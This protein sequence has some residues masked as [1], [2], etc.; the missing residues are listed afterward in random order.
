MKEKII[1]IKTDDPFCSMAEIARKVGASREYVRQVL[2]Q[3]NISTTALKT[4]RCFG[5]K[6]PLSNTSSPFCSTACREAY[7]TI[8]VSCSN[9]DKLFHRKASQLYQYPSRLSGSHKGMHVF[10]GNKCK[11][12]F[13]GRVYGFG[14]SS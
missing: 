3:A 8:Q 2:K 1:K 7:M 9:C 12:E 5:C 14:S 6:K 4:Y 11:G 10:C 13:A